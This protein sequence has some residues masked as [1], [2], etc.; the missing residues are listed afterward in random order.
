ML[1]GAYFDG[2]GGWVV[3]S[4]YLCTLLRTGKAKRSV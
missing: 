2:G 4:K 1:V 3:V